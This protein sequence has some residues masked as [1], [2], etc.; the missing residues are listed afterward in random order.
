[1]F[2]RQKIGAYPVAWSSDIKSNIANGLPD[3]ENLTNNC[4]QLYVDELEPA[5]RRKV[6]A[7]LIF[8]KWWP[9][10]VTWQSDIKSGATNGFFYIAL[11]SDLK[12]VIGKK[13]LGVLG[14][15]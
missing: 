12:K 9:Y 6:Q 7:L 13:V 8:S 2:S 15:S 3:P 5:Y 1:M 4:K 14:V 11:K 10:S